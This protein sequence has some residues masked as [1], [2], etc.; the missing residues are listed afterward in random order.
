M[1]PLPYFISHD[2]DEHD[3]RQATATTTKGDDDDD[4]DDAVASPASDDSVAPRHVTVLVES[5]R[6]GQRA[7]A[8]S[9]ALGSSEAP[10]AAAAARGEDHLQAA[11]AIDTANDGDDK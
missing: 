3:S 6:A 1:N 8:S 4:A 7:S 11:E 9:E 5:G 10:A 2:A